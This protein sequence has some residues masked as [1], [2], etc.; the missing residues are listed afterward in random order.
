M[1][2]YS[3]TGTFS[4]F[5]SVI[6]CLLLIFS[7]QVNISLAQSLTD[8]NEE[9]DTTST[10]DDSAVDQEISSDDE[11]IASSQDLA[12]SSQ[13]K[14]VDSQD[15]LTTQENNLMTTSATDPSPE[16]NLVNQ[17]L[18]L[19]TNSLPKPDH[20]TGALVYEYPLLTPPGRNK[21]E[22]DLKLT[23]SS[24]DQNNSSIF[25]Y[26]WS[27][28]IPYLER[29]NRKGVDQLYSTNLFNSSLSGEL[30]QVASSSNYRA[31]VENGDFLKYEYSNNS[32][33]ATDKFGTTYKFGP[34]S[35][36]RQDDSSDTGK[37]F[38][39]MIEE[40]RDTNGNF[41]RYEYYKDSGQIY[42]S[43]IIYTGKGSTDGVFEVDFLR[44]ER[45]DELF[46]KATGFNV[47][48]SYLIQQVTVS[49]ENGWV[50]KYSMDSAVGTTSDYSLLQSITESGQ[51]DNGVV[52]S[53]QPTEFSYQGNGTGWDLSTSWD[54]QPGYQEGARLADVNGDGLVDLAVAYDRYTDPTVKNIYLNTGTDWVL[55]STWSTNFPDVKFYYDSTSSSHPDEF[56]NISLVDL[57]G[58]GLVDVYDPDEGESYINNGTKPNLLSEIT[59]PTEGTTQIEYKQTPLYTDDQGFLLNNNLPFVLDTVSSIT[60]SDGL[61]NSRTSSYEYSGGDYYYGSFDDRKFA[62]FAVIAETDGVGNITKAYYHQGNDTNST[63]GEFS[64]SK[65]KI[66][67]VYKVEEYDDAGNLF[68]KTINKWEDYDLGD[69]ADF[70]KL[71]Q[72]TK[73][74]YDGDSDHRDTAE[75]FVYS[76]TTGNLTEDKQ[77]G[78]VTASNDGSFTDIDGDILRTNWDYAT[79]S[80]GIIKGL[81]SNKSTYDRF[82]GLLTSTRYYYDNQNN[83]TVTVGNPTKEENLVSGFSTYVDTEK[84]YNT[85]GLVT[86]EKDPR[87]KTTTYAYDTYNLYPATVTNP[88]SQQTSYTYDYSSGKVKQTTDPNGRVFE[89]VYDG[90]D[91]VKEEKQPDL[92]SPSTLVTKTSYVYNDSSS[93]RSIHETN[94]LD[95]SNTKEKYVYQDGLGRVIQERTEAQNG[96]SYK[97]RDFIYND[98]GLIEKESLPYFASGSSY[99]S[100]TATESLYT[101]YAY[102][103]MKRPTSITTAVGSTTSSYDDWLTTTYDARGNRKDIYRTAYGFLR[104]IVEYNDG[105]QYETHYEDDLFGRLTRI[106]DSLSN[107]RSFTYDRIGRRLTAEDLHNPSD[108]TYGTWDYTYDNAGNITQTVDPNNQTINYTYDDTNRVLTEDYTGQT[109]TEIT[110]GYDSCTNGIGKLCSATSTDAAVSYMYNP[111]GLISSETKGI[112]STNYTTEY[113]YDRLGNQTLIT[114]PDSSE[115]KYVR[116][117]AGDLNSVEQRENGGSFSPV[118]STIDYSPTGAISNL[119]HS[120][121]LTTTNTYDPTKI[122]RLTDKVTT[123]GTTNLQDISY[124]YD[125]VGNI[126]QIVDDSDIGSAKTATYDYDDLNRLTS[127]AITNAASGGNYSRTYSYNQIGNITSKSDQGSYTYGG[128]SGSS[129]A[130]PHA[131]TSLAGVAYAYDHNGNLTSVGSST[132]NSW[133]YNNRLEQTVVGTTTTSYAYDYTGDRVEK[134]SGSTPT[135]YPFNFYEVAGATTTKHIYADDMLLATI[136]SAATSTTYHNSLDH[137]QSTAVVTDEGGN[138]AELLDYFPFGGIRLDEIATSTG[139]MSTSTTEEFVYQNEAFEN[140]WESWSWG[141]TI[142]PAAT[143]TIYTGSSSMAVAYSYNSAGLSMRG[144]ALDTAT[145]DTIEIPVYVGSST[146]ITLTLASRDSSGNTLD[147][148][149]LEDYIPG[150]SWQAN[151]WQLASVPLGDIGLTN[152]N[153]S[154]QIVIQSNLAVTVYYDAIRFT[155]TTSSGGGSSS[156]DV[157]YKQMKR[158]IGQTFDPETDLLYLNARY[159]DGD[160]GQFLNQDPTFLIIGNAKKIKQKTGLELQQY[161]SDPQSLNSYSYTRN[162]PMRLVDPE[163]DYYRE[164]A[165]GYTGFKGYGL[166]LIED[167]I[168]VA[169]GN[170]NIARNSA[171][172]NGYTNSNI[173]KSIIF[174]EQSHG[175]DDII[176]DT[177]PIFG[178]GNTVGLG[179]ITIN[180]IKNLSLGYGSYSREQLLDP[181]INVAEI[182]NRINSIGKQLSELGITSDNKNYV[183]YISSTY[184][185]QNNLGSLTDYGRRIQAYYNDVSSGKL[186][187]PE[188][189]I[190][191]KVMQSLNSLVKK[192]SK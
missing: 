188:N 21:I 155:G 94:H 41:I 149:S 3:V 182:N 174:E 108:S 103:A 115:V 121:G 107:E 105:S 43:K 4:K 147:S 135:I 118:V 101:T 18:S 104:K 187:I 17:P 141:V 50:K 85:Y 111:L 90:L 44:E 136:E 154:A 54:V 51:D 190:A 73:L 9:S 110:Y 53:L 52:S 89:T 36:S 19:L 95:G 55:N 8:Y 120:N 20:I 144:A 127:A 160:R 156:S 172:I 151:T 148:V 177:H 96:T 58:D 70:V 170:I 184:N 77:W 31:K 152:Y 119:V 7:A 64:D 171:T 40:V 179:Q 67:K 46:S 80:N 169:R 13:K 66:G 192:I 133:D 33:I 112:N 63:Q 98:L 91:R 29:I 123:N 161:L 15:D 173:I 130:N 38:K 30:V 134:T 92:A 126:T 167:T 26:G 165:T 56:Y 27:I 6:F 11:E 62:G 163:G 180:D 139:S 109:G 124:T 39:W 122:Y 178:S 87:D 86:E 181:S 47:L 25:G 132:T 114:Y 10:E 150:G 100:P 76:D 159:Y 185:S 83:G 142:D 99:T 138:L 82:G 146:S 24:Q 12:G 117:A 176:T 164:A 69:D 140:G 125:P 106:I 2:S 186:L 102:D 60:Y 34:D 75:N 81:P 168:G 93:P 145:Y 143:S 57:N 84:T 49:V 157:T 137:L 116:D 61:D 68:R 28:N 128:A 22:P 88:L 45:S 153:N 189:N 42:P 79:D 71:T 158:Y 74:T 72:T 16:E 131:V 37:V 1:N 113:G 23:Y 65:S 129:Y 191:G 5:L 97:V 162:N 59:Y 183:G 175:L 48:T 32:W 166:G 14:G 78:E 35:S